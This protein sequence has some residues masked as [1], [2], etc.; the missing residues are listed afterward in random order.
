VFEGFDVKEEKKLVFP[1][2]HLTTVKL[3]QSKKINQERDFRKIKKARRRHQPCP[4]TWSI[5]DCPVQKIQPF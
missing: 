5:C 3:Y 2:D 1:I 4:C